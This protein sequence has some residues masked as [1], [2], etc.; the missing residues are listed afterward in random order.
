[1]LFR[2][3]L[4]ADFAKNGTLAGADDLDQPRAAD[5]RWPV[6]AAMQQF[7]RLEPGGRA[8]GKIVI[9]HDERRCV[10]Y[11]ERPLKTYWTVGGGDFTTTLSNL[12]QD[13]SALVRTVKAE[14]AR[15]HARA[16]A[17]GGEA[18]A[19][20][21]DLAWRQAMGA[22]IIAAD[23]DGTMLMFPKENT[24]NGCIG[25]V[26][27]FFPSAPLFL[28]EAPALLAAQVRPLLEYGSMKHRWK[29]PFAPHDLGVYPKA[30]GQVY[31][32]AE[33]KIGRAHV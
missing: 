5:D 2:S 24:S 19:Q 32:G 31:G 7:G 33:E 14:N 22:H 20:L 13:D 4:R 23:A 30:N 6:L 15:L 3:V 29:F 10:E 26:D 27:V 17:V 9:A 25:T 28:E 21:C 18:Y 8:E 12:L 11:F 16:A 1:M